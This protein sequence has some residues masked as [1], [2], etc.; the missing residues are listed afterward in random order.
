M[1][2]G[3]LK[4]LAKLFE[5]ENE[6]TLSSDE[7]EAIS[8]KRTPI[9]KE[10]IKVLKNKANGSI[11]F[12][13]NINE[14]SISS[15]LVQLIKILQIPGNLKIDFAGFLEDEEG[16]KVFVFPS[17]NSSIQIGKQVTIRLESKQQKIETIQTL[18]L[19]KNDEFLDSWFDSHNQLNQF[20]KSGLK[21]VRL[22]NIT[23]FFRPIYVTVS[24]IFE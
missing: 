2:D 9:L 7:S 13:K 1:F 3:C 18:Q 10:G 23:V 11:I 15:F 20:S 6:L 19:M 17:E 12:T 8:N 24:E 5:I 16:S 22:L 21:P 4:R 14:G